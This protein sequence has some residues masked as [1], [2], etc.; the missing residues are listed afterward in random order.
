MRIKLFFSIAFMMVFALPSITLAQKRDTLKTNDGLKYI[1]L[2]RGNGQK[3]WSGK[4]VSIYY[5]VTFLNGK[6]FDSN[7]E[8]KPYKVLLTKEE[9]IPGLL[10]GISL[11]T[12]GAKYKFIIPPNLAYGSEGMFN[13]E[14]N[15]KYLVEPN[16]SIIYEVEL[17]DFKN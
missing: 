3:P 7:L 11:M 6:K 10:E 5:T 4:Q 9:L 16:T 17:V 12:K 8:G 1:I 14:G 13:P 15:P 2:K